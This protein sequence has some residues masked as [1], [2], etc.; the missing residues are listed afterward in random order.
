MPPEAGAPLA[1]ALY[2]G[3]VGHWRYGP[4]RHAL[5]YRLCYFLLDLDEASRL[6]ATSRWFGWERRAWLAFR[7]ADHGAGGA[8][9]LHAWLA[10]VLAGAGLGSGPWRYR[11]LCLPRVGG[12][13][14]N[15]IS[16]VYC[17]GADGR[18]AAMI[19]EVNNTFGERIAYCA[20][21]ATA[22]RPVRQR[23]D[24]R[25]FVSPFFAMAGH[26]EF[27]LDE[28]GDELDLVIDYH[29]EE[30]LRLRARFHGTRVPWSAAALRRAATSFPAATLKVITAIHYE[31]LKLWLKGVPVRRH[32]A[33][34]KSIVI[35]SES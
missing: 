3:E 10:G 21:V 7:A 2:F 5:N 9:P 34:S 12:Y 25:L 24:K 19:Y 16:V 13:V 1:S 4:T 32:V 30:A 27:T 6:A 18:L 29:D 28:P 31:A 22:S 35:G 14:F 15:P 11:L 17:H 26:Y 33:A 20:P 23:C 8:Q